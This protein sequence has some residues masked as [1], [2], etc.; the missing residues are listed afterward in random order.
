MRLSDRL[1]EFLA[2]CE[3]REVSLKYLRDELRIDPNS[4][5]WNGLREYLRQLTDKKIVKPSGRNDGIYKVIRR[6]NPVSVFGAQRFPPIQIV[7]PKDFDTGMEME[8]SEHLVIRQ[9]DLILLSGMSNQGKTTLCLNFAGENIDQHPILM[10]NEYTTIDNLPNSRF[11]DR[12][13]K[14]SWVEWVNGTGEDK[15]VLLPVRE[16]YAEHIVK[17]KINIIDWIN[18]STGEHYMIGS[19]LEGIKRELGKGVAIIAIQKAEGAV[20]G[21]G[22][23]FTKDFA[24][25]ELLIDKM[26]NSFDAIMTLGKVKESTKPIMGKTYAY[27]IVGG[28]KITNFRE[29]VKCKSC[30]G[31]G[32]KGGKICDDCLQT[33]YKDK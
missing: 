24:D 5:A 9:G 10:G 15:F 32:Y 20:A 8:F 27:H 25:I 1:K 23:Q 33:G 18:V 2:T 28:V 22:G 30:H 14:M 12:L 16:D 17:D 26:P 21:R 29:V 4:P 3:G 6:V 13:D 11:M 19:I 31:A 7:F